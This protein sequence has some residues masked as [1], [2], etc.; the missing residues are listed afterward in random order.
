M[1]FIPRSQRYP[2]S[3]VITEQKVRRLLTISGNTSFMQVSAVTSCACAAHS[4]IVFSQWLRGRHGSKFDVSF[5]LWFCVGND[6]RS[7]FHGQ[8]GG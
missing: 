2:R 3:K 8:E 4:N 6:R 7:V 5:L 1:C